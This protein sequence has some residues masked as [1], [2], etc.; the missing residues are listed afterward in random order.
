MINLWLVKWPQCQ[1]SNTHQCSVGLLIK[2]Y[3]ELNRS[4]MSPFIR[5]N[6]ITSDFFLPTS[7]LNYW[8]SSLLFLYRIVKLNRNKVTETVQRLKSWIWSTL[9]I[10]S[11][12]FFSC[13]GQGRFRCK[14]RWEEEKMRRRRKK[15]ET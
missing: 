3:W 5:I 1:F 2:R 10:S 13:D 7:L 11:F 6:E 12:F 8:H 15:N 9:S 4:E 14:E